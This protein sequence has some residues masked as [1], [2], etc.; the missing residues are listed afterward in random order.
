[1]NAER[2]H[3]K[4]SALRRNGYL[5]DGERAAAEASWERRGWL[6]RLVRV[7][8]PT[9]EILSTQGEAPDFRAAA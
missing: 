9:V 3:T 6:G 8:E 1:M 2:K 5:T 7:A 4:D